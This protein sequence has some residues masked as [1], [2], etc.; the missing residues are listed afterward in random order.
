[1]RKMWKKCLAA[2]TLATCFM[3]VIPNSMMVQADANDYREESLKDIKNVI[4][5]IGDGMGPEHV[6]AGAIQKGEPLHIQ[7]IEQTSFSLT[8]SEG[9]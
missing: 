5:M 9:V 6:R 2:I 4:I 1:M 7:T 8:A 3:G